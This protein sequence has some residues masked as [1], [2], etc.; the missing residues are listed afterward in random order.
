MVSFLYSRTTNHSPFSARFSTA[1][2]LQTLHQRTLWASLI[3]FPISPLQQ[4][5]FLGHLVLPGPLEPWAIPVPG[6][7]E[8]QDKY[9]LSLPLGPPIEGG[10]EAVNELINKEVWDQRQGQRSFLT[11]QPS[12]ILPPN[13]QARGKEASPGRPSP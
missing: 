6:Y 7:P 5:G 10:N 12:P 13:P 4:V 9:T 2:V 1:L 3:S 8:K 11:A